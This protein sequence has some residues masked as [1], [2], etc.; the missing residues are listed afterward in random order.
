[1]EEYKIQFYYALKEPGTLMRPKNADANFYIRM[2]LDE[3]CNR[4]SSF[5]EF[6]TKNNS[7]NQMVF[8]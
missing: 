1:M 8:G 3:A 4:C 5:L 7:N 6:L 2:Y